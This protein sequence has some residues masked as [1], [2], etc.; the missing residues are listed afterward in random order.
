[1]RADLFYADGH[2]HTH[3]HTHIQ[4]DAETASTNSRCRNFGNA[5]KNQNKI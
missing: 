5:P 2:T 1:M 4:T 3:T